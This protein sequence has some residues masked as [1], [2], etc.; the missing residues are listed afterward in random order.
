MAPQSSEHEGSDDI[1]LPLGSDELVVRNRYEVLSIVND[2]SIGLL[3][4]IG[5][6]LFF[7][8]S[9]TTAGTWFFVVGSLQLLLRPG[10]RLARRVHLKRFASAADRA[11]YDDAE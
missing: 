6:V 7:R 5:S 11:R 3:F 1:Q 8:E 10:I 4:V 2:I 9:T